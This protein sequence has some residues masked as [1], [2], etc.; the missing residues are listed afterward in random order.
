MPYK[1]RHDID[2]GDMMALVEDCHCRASC[3]AQ[4]YF[5]FVET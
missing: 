2:G 4:K 5:C 3:H 1:Y